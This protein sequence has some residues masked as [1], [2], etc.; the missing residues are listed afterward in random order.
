[1]LIHFLQF[2][3]INSPGVS[4]YV[5]LPGHPILTTST[6]ANLEALFDRS[7]WFRPRQLSIQ[8][9]CAQSK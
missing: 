4:C 9:W 5:L 8:T 3:T 7:Q 2:I 1:M 6:R